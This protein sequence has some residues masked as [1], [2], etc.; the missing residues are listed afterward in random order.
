MGFRISGR[1]E[2]PNTASPPDPDLVRR[3]S[4]TFDPAD[5]RPW[6][7][8]IIGRGQFTEDGRLWGYQLP[9][10]RYYLRINNA[11]PGWTLKSA[12]WNGRDISDVPLELDRDV[13]G[14]VITFTDRPATFSGQV[15]NASGAAD[16]S[17]TVLIF[18]AD[19]GSWADYG[20]FPRRLRAVRADRDGRFTA[21]GF[22]PGNYLVAAVGEETSSDWQN[23]RML[24]ALARLATKVT[25]ADGESRQLALSTLTVPR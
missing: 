1:A 8:S 7:S 19:S 3:M 6:V 4:A 21:L 23:P 12:M 22:P 5:A 17:A 24:Q 25:I 15:Q 2:F 10:G 18:P 13:S 16:A 11:P 9:P 20:G 14:V